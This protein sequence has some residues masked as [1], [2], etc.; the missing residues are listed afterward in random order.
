MKIF[1]QKYMENIVK[2]FLKFYDNFQELKKHDK[3]IHKTMLY[4]FFYLYNL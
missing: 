3:N 4:Y 2:I 1:E